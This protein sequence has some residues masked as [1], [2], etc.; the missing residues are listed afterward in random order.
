MQPLEQ[1]ELENAGGC[2]PKPALWDSHMSAA[3]LPSFNTS[4]MPDR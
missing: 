2:L 4:A 1:L 3:W